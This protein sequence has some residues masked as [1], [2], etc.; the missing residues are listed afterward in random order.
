M[1]YPEQIF[2]WKLMAKIANIQNPSRIVNAIFIQR[3]SRFNSQKP[4][5]FFCSVSKCNFFIFF[6]INANSVAS[7]ERQS[8]NV[9]RILKKRS[10]VIQN[11]NISWMMCQMCFANNN[12][13]ENKV[14]ILRQ[15]Y[16]L[17]SIHVSNEFWK[18]TSKPKIRKLVWHQVT[19]TAIYSTCKVTCKRILWNRIMLKKIY[20]NR[21]CQ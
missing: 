7:T 3:E 19:L 15:H 4:I 1:T 18:Q 5:S 6:P 8:Q 20:F 21:F 14:N 16:K 9:Y 10:N 2:T 17:A 12:N 13:N 11:K